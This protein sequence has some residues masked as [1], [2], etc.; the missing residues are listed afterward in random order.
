M[1]ALGVVPLIDPAVAAGVVLVAHLV[2]GLVRHGL[3]RYI[4]GQLETDA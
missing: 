1:V 3:A 4:L 2:A